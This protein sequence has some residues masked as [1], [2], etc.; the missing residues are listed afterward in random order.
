MINLE[1][2]TTLAQNN[3]EMTLDQPADW[4]ISCKYQTLKVQIVSVMA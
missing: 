3:M 1:E 4:T 2:S